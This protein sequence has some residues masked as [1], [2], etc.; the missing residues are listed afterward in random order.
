M[1]GEKNTNGEKPLI[2]ME[3]VRLQRTK[4]F[5]KIKMMRCPWSCIFVRIVVV[6]KMEVHALMLGLFAL[7][8]M[9]LVLQVITNQN[10]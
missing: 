4:W 7:L 6:K 2:K 8:K 5:S 9:R 10:C 3:T 1:Y